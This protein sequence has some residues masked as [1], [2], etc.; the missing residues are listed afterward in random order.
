MFYPTEQFPFTRTLEDHW[1]AIRGEL[2]G[3]PD[4]QF[5]PWPETFLYEAGWDVFG[6]YAFGER[7]AEHCALCPETTRLVETIPGLVT[8]GFSS[9]K[10]MTRIKPHV[11]YAYTYG[12]DGE[13][14]TDGDPNGDVLRC[15]LGLIVP[16]AYT[17]N[18]CAIRV[19][20]DTRAW[21]QGKCLV[22]DDTIIHEAWN[23]TFMT[24]VVLLLDFRKAAFA[25]VLGA[26]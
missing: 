23:L 20:G 1:Q 26:C 24:R 21:T 13:I 12:G 18:G 3:L 2:L 22:F 14:R 4:T 19:G 16:D 9:L 6:L 8:A 11:G 7:I 25:D 10:P 17:E 15:H 5:T